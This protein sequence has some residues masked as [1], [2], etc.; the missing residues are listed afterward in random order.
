MTKLGL[1]TGWCSS[2]LI[3]SPERVRAPLTRWVTLLMGLDS[4]A[5]GF[6]A[7]REFQL[8]AGRLFV[9][10]NRSVLLAALVPPDG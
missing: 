6:R 5:V 8:L 9:C 2:M 10:H 4:F 3:V 1:S 7:R